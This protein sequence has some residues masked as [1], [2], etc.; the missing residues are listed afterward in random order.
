MLQTCTRTSPHALVVK[1]DAFDGVGSCD[2]KLDL[3][4]I[5]L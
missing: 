4:C 3:M 2:G 5:I 1:M